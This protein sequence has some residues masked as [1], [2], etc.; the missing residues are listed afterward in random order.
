MVENCERLPGYHHH[1]G[2]LGVT[3]CAPSV[4]PASWEAARSAVFHT[5]FLM[6]EIHRITRERY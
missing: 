2:Q 1:D 5:G 6:Y 3:K 4:A